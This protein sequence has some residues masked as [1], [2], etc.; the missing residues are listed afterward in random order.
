MILQVV[1]KYDTVYQLF[2]MLKNSLFLLNQNMQYAIHSP[3][4]ATVSSSLYIV[5]NLYTVELGGLTAQKRT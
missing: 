3:I 5:A 1:G 4:S 2:K